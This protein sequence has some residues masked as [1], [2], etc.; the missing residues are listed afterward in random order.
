MDLLSSGLMCV[1]KFTS[2]Y[3][4]F[5]KMHRQENWF[6][7]LPHG[8]HFRVLLIKAKRAV[9]RHEECRPGAHLPCLGREPVAG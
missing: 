5:K 4:V 6:F 1:K 2:F 9:A 3:Q 7:F 8:V